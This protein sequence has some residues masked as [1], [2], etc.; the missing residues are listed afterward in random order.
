MRHR[1]YRT[2]K[3]VEPADNDMTTEPFSKDEPGDSFVPEPE[4]KKAAKRKRVANASS[5]ATAPKKP[6]QKKAEA[7]SKT[8]AST[9]STHALG[10]AF[11]THTLRLLKHHLFTLTHTGQRN[12]R[13][14]D[15]CGHWAVPS[16]PTPIP[17]II[18]CKASSRL[19]PDAVRALEGA[20]AGSG[21]FS[22]GMGI[23]V[24]KVKATRG[25]REALQRSGKRVGY[26]CVEE[27]RVM[28]MIWNER[29]NE[30]G[31]GGL[32][33]TKLFG[34]EAVGLR[35]AGTLVGR[36][37]GGLLER[38]DVRKDEEREEMLGTDRKARP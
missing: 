36:P 8:T 33:V 16:H 18:Q 32:E 12:D 22:E 27:D 5:T 20:L 2:K 13:G 34:C 26:F 7:I 9:L 11:E 10:T 14:I 23:L 3:V 35:W 28:Q 25:V 4:A 24:G 38:E 30:E 15:L 19:G 21:R 6:R 31:L 17:V 29:A 37:L 1:Q